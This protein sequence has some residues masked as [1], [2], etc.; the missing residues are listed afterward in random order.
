MAYSDGRDGL[1]ADIHIVSRCSDRASSHADA[2]AERLGCSAPCCDCCMQKAGW[3]LLRGS[4]AQLRLCA[5]PF[6]LQPL[7]ALCPWQDIMRGISPKQ[8]VP[9]DQWAIHLANKIKFHWRPLLS[10]WAGPAA[11]RRWRCW[12]ASTSADGMAARSLL[13]GA[14]GGQQARG[15]HSCCAAEHAWGL[16]FLPHVQAACTAPSS[17]TSTLRPTP[18]LACPRQTGGRG[19]LLGHGPAGS[20]LPQQDAAVRLA[21]VRVRSF[22]AVLQPADPSLLWCSSRRVR[23]LHFLCTIRCDREDIQV[24]GTADGGPVAAYP[25]LAQLPLGLSF[26]VASALS[27]GCPLTYASP[28]A[29]SSSHPCA[30]PHI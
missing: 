17:L 15:A 11:S 6:S 13:T 4:V 20:C 8:D 29:P 9:R 30:D 16:R 23:A 1:L 18:T 26:W 12:M 7:R 28:H 3:L 22:A 2:L 27:R 14:G 10:E 5:E 25:C 19:L 24:G 21:A